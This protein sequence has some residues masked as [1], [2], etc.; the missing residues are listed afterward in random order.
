MSDLTFNALDLFIAATFF[1]V[2]MAL[3]VWLRAKPNDKL[4]KQD[5]DLRDQRTTAL[6]TL[7]GDWTSAAVNVV[8]GV[9]LGTAINGVVQLIFTGVWV[10]VLNIAVL[11][12]ALFFIVFLH[13]RL[14]KKIFP[15]GIR[16]AREPEKVSRKPLVQRLSLPAGLILGVVLAGAG[17]DDWLLSCLV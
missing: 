2:V 4:D 15:S 11:S 16:P 14:G 6:F 1:C 13:D 5:S 12:A 7:A 8:I 10:V 9:L 3:V 17:L